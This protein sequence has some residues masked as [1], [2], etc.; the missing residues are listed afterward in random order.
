MTANLIAMQHTKR[1]HCV[2]YLILYSI[3]NVQLL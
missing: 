2:L 3:V 1:T